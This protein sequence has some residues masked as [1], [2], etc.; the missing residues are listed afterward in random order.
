MS[1]FTCGPLVVV[2]KLNLRVVSAGGNEINCDHMPFLD[3]LVC[4][5]STQHYNLVL[6]NQIIVRIVKECWRVVST[7]A[8]LHLVLHQSADAL[9][10]E[11]VV[12]LATGW[13]CYH[14]VD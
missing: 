1:V 2:L 4:P 12:N 9:E 6:S 14:R 5:Q 13:I 7:K 11:S 8:H 10:L 3:K